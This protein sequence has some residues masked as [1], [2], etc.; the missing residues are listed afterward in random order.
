MYVCRKTQKSA[1]SHHSDWHLAKMKCSP[2][3]HPLT[4]NFFDTDATKNNLM[5]V[6]LKIKVNDLCPIRLMFSHKTVRSL[7]YIIYRA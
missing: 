4:A 6:V 1:D 7:L 2:S 5:V 3:T